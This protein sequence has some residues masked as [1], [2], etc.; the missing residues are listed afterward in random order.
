MSD[1]ASDMTIPKAMAA[2]LRESADLCL[3][4]ADEIERLEREIEEIKND[5]AWRYSG[6]L[7]WL[8]GR[9]VD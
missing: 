4:A 2:D 3:R 8:R 9:I 1:E 6:V 5:H 7:G